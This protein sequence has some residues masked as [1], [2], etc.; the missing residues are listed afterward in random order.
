MNSVDYVRNDPRYH[1]LSKASTGDYHTI[2]M[3]QT[4]ETYKCF[5]GLNLIVD[6]GRGHGAVL[7]MIVSK[8]PTNKGI[9]FDPTPVIEKA[10]SY[11]GIE[12]DTYFVYQLL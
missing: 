7:N 6:V 4:R 11:P 2:F 3:K 8:Y 9:N 12:S 1:D 5:K 10:P